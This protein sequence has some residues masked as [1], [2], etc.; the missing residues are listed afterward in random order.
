MSQCILSLPQNNQF[1]LFTEENG[2]NQA[3]FHSDIQESVH[4]SE[5]KLVLME[6]MFGVFS[7]SINLKK[8]S[9]SVSQHQR[10]HGKCM[11]R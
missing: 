1:Q 10:L 3:I 11:R 6:E 2:L 7:E 8:L 4:A 9:N 5:K